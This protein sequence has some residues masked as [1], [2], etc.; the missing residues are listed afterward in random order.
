MS[1]YMVW[2]DLLRSL[3][4]PLHGVVREIFT[5][6]EGVSVRMPLT[7]SN[8]NWHNWPNQSWKGISS[9][10]SNSGSREFQAWLIYI[11][12]GVFKDHSISISAEPFSACEQRPLAGFLQ[13]TQDGC[14]SSG[15]HG[16]SQPQQKGVPH[17][18]VPF[19]ENEKTF[20]EFFS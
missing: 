18:C 14:H 9:H 11:L 15:H 17:S 3:W 7:A 10:S 13:W 16:H 4:N 2:L 8:K 6:V 5:L 20:L 12:K 1:F 19:I